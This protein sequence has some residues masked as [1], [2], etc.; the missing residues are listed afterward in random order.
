MKMIGLDC[1]PS[2]LPLKTPS[3]ERIASFRK[4]LDAIGFFDHIQP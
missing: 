1:G 2:R 4:E 3:A